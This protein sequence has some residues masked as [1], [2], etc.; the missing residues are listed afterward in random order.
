MAIILLII[1]F[2]STGHHDRISHL[3][4]N[5]FV[6]LCTAITAFEECLKCST[7]PENKKAEVQQALHKAKNRS[8][9]QEQNV[10]VTIYLTRILFNAAL[11]PITFV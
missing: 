5:I 6:F 9:V 7:I 1:P 11:H 8:D 10:R 4:N 2:Y 3:F